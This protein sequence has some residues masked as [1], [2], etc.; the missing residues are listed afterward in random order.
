MSCV[1]VVPAEY[2]P[3]A[4]EELRL[5]DDENPPVRPKPRK[6]IV[7]QDALPGVI[8]YVL[9]VCVVAWLAGYSFF[10]SNWFVAGRVDGTLIRDGEWW[11]TIT[12]LTLHSGVRHLLGNLVFGV[13]FGIFAGRLL[14]SG[15]AWLAVVVAGALGNT[16]NTLLLDSTHR[17]IGASTAVFATLGILAGY[18]WRGQ[19]MAQDRWSTRFGPIIGGLA[20]LMFTGTG[21]ENT[22]IGAHLLGF[23]CGFATGMLLTVIGRMPAPPRVQK[24]AGGVA[25]GLIAVSW[26]IALQV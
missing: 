4:A 9:V 20:L 17:S 16:A 10:G 24:A 25:V 6:R 12:A 21:D 2:S 7:Y 26:L 1:L 11:R 19:L 3:R 5:Y 23:V 8:G 22:D 18:V 15:V 14:G 13:F